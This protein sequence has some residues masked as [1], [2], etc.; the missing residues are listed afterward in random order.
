MS[1]F[2]TSDQKISGLL[3][4]V[5]AVGDDDA[6]HV[7]LR[8][9]FVDALGQLEPDLVVHGLA[10]DVGDLFTG[11]LGDVGELRH[12][13]DEVV[14]REGAGLVA[15]ISLRGLRAGDRAAGGEDFD[16]WQRRP[17]SLGK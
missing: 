16:F 2:T 14:H 13:L 6:V 11:Q 7:V 9:Q 15:G 17:G 8:E 12:G 5:G 10:A 4:R 3:H 1:L